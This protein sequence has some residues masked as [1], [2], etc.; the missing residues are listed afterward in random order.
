MIWSTISPPYCSF[1]AHTRSTN[2][3][4]PM[5]RRS[6]PSLRSSRSTTTCVAM[7]AWS[8]PGTQSASKPCIRARRINVS[9]QRAPE[10]VTDVQPPGDVRRRDHDAV[11]LA[12]GGEVA[13]GSIPGRSTPRP[14]AARPRRG[15]TAGAS[16]AWMAGDMRPSLRNG[17][18]PP[19]RPLDG[20]L[21]SGGSASV[22]STGG[23][24][25]PKPILFLSD[26]G[27]RDEFVGVCHSV[28][29]SIAPGAPVI[30][31][32][33]GVPPQD[34][35]AGALTFRD[36]IAFAPQDCR[37]ARRGGPGCGTDR[38]AVAVE[39]ASRRILVGPDNGLLS[40]A[41]DAAAEPHP[42]VRDHRPRRA[43]P[44]GLE[45]VPRARRV[46]PGGGASGGRASAEN[47][48]PRVD[49]GELVTLTLPEADVLTGEIRAQVLDVDRFGNVRLNVRPADLP[50][51]G[52]DGLDAEGRDDRR[53][54]RRRRACRPTRKLHPASSPSSRT[55]GDGSR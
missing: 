35:Q 8:M 36:C 24:P 9:S 7:P 37:A 39:T 55:R 23:A 29:A 47:L 43:P 31:L 25:M 40:L 45:R 27:V 46:R 34:V 6:M 2:A 3:S 15:R 1:H 10:R 51:A 19:D 49:T 21:R 13:R 12:I 44:A 4:R 48:G 53:V 30:D 32:S 33:H 18:P 52:I 54:G 11:R 20:R 22:R 41:W 5:S 16:P 42:R 38:K 28:I 26:L 14:I 50:A 17:S